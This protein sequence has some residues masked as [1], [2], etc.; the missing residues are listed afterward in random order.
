MQELDTTNL[1]S[2]FKW[3]QSWMK[4][5]WSSQSCQNFPLSRESLRWLGRTGW[6][7]LITLIKQ[8]LINNFKAEVCASN[9]ERYNCWSQD[10]LTIEANFKEPLKMHL[11]FLAQDS[12][13][14]ACIK[15]DLPSK[16]WTDWYFYISDTT[17]SISMVL[18]HDLSSC[19]VHHVVARSYGDKAWVLMCYKATIE[20]FLT[21]A[22]SYARLSFVWCGTVLVN[23]PW[24]RE[25]PFLGRN[26]TAKLDCL[27][28]LASTHADL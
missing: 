4:V 14:F 23:C 28:E 6:V 5:I 12:F 21:W 18:Y 25:L 3:W 16:S 11:P 13:L 19:H 26:C 8:R 17:A 15:Y 1:L 27:S 20:E 7:K 24:L 2:L 9:H 10:E 22:W